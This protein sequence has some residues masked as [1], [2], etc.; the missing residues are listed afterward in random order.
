[1]AT[2]YNRATLTYSGGTTVSNTVTG[3]VNETL[4]IEKHAPIDTYTANGRLVYVLSLVNSGT[5]SLNAITLTDDLGGYSGTGGTLYPL[6]YLPDSAAYYVNGV[7]QTPPTVTVGP[8]L[9]F[10]GISVPAGGNAVIVYEAEV[11]DFAPITEGASI[12]NTVTANGTLAEAVSASETVTVDV[13]PDLAIVKSLSPTNVEEDGVITYTFLVENRGNAPAVT[14]DDIVISDI[15]DPIL[16][17]SAVTLDGETLSPGTGYVYNEATGEFTTVSGVVTVP[18]AEITV[19][20]DGRYQ[21]IPGTA[22]LTVS[23]TV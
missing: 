21:V 7:L 16:T 15:F 3:T 22:V 23:G 14:T 12:V 10:T 19:G 8:P 17:L 20:E 4:S 2:F 18:A 1:M 6:S 11:T 5:T 13:G 9:V